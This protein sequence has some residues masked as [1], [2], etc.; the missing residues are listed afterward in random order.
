MLAFQDSDATWNYSI[1]CILGELSGQ[2]FP[3]TKREQWHWQ[4][5]NRR[6]KEGLMQCQETQERNTE[7]LP[8]L[9]A[10]QEV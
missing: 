3:Q 4:E 2:L 8:K 9:A 1:G 7:P 10:I 6:I 5:T